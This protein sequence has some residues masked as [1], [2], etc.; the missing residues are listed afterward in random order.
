LLDR[1]VSHGARGVRVRRL[2]GDR[3]G[4]IRFTR[5]LRNASVSLSEMIGS[6][7]ART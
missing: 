5:F 6:A 4:E 7:F 2:G 3:A 1:L